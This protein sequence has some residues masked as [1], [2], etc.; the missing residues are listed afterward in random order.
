MIEWFC[1]LGA[2]W[3]ERWGFSVRFI[4]LLLLFIFFVATWYLLVYV[5]YCWFTFNTLGYAVAWEVIWPRLY[6]RSF[7]CFV[8]LLSSYYALSILILCC[9]HSYSLYLSFLFLSYCW[10]GYLKEKLFD[11]LIQE[12]FSYRI[13]LFIFNLLL[14]RLVGMFLCRC[15]NFS[16]LGDIVGILLLTVS[17]IFFIIGLWWLEPCLCGSSFSFLYYES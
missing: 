17:E 8:C 6:G 1:K 13:F 14:V 9:L 7:F 11:I 3:S 5:C 10:V 16:C 4:Y 2:F 12:F 15:F